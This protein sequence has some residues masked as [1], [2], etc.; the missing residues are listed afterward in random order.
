MKSLNQNRSKLFPI[1]IILGVSLFFIISYNYHF[2]DSSQEKITD[3][4]FIKTKVPEDIVIVAIDSQSINKLGSWP[5]QRK[6]FSDLIGKLQSAKRIAIDVSFSENSRFGEWDDNTLASALK[7][8]VPQIILPIILRNDGVIEAKPLESFAYANK[9]FVNIFPDSDGVVREAITEINTIPSFSKIA[10]GNRGEIEK[11]RIFYYGKEKTFPTIPLI[12]VL[13]NKV[14]ESFFKDSLVF[15]GATA[16]DLHDFANTPMGRLPGVEV[17]ANITASLLETKFFKES[18]GLLASILILIASLLSQIA[19]A[20]IKKFSKLLLTLIGI[21]FFINISAI[22]LFTYFIIIPH[23]YISLAFIASTAILIIF[24]YI[25]ES[26][27][28]RFIRNAFKYYLTP[29][30]IE[31][32]MQ[33][34]D[35]LRLGGEKRELVVFFSDIRGFTTISEKLEPEELVHL[36]NRYLSLMTETIMKHGGLVDKYIG[37]A[38]MAFWGAPIENQNK[39][40]DACRAVQEM[41]ERLEELNKELKL[42]GKAEIKIGMGLTLGEVIVGN[43]GSNKRFNYTVMGDSVNLASRLESQTKEFGVE[44]IVNESFAKALRDDSSFKTQELGTITVKGKTEPTKIFELLY[45]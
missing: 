18:S 29:E 22:T 13:Q 27:E 20:M 23:L 30:V 36:M 25:T 5:L 12:D 9:A 45:K 38:V 43:M 26:K 40:E 1:F 31:E 8:S 4:F 14:P 42:E 11:F 24:Q 7:T 34:P 2:F 35:K 10:S 17:H 16:P 37:D 15:V 19:I 33:N 28:K 39:V 21:L 32:I 6:I 41:S 3:R 44:T